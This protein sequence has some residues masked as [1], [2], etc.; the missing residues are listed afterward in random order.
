[1]FGWRAD[2]RELWYRT[3]DGKIMAVAVAEG[4]RFGNARLFQMPAGTVVSATNGERILAA[5]PTDASTRVPI[6]V[7]LN[8]PA[9]VQK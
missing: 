3:T 2:G 7:M 8:W 4:P 9:L 1:M 5:V 6:T